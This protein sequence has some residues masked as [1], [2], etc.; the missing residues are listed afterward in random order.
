MSETEFMNKNS[1]KND[2]NRKNIALSQFLFA[3]TLQSTNI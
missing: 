2:N 1:E 3:I